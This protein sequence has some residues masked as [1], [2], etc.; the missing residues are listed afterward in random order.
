MTR[1]E[2]IEKLKTLPCYDEGGC[3]SCED[4]DFQKAIDMAA[5]S[6]KIVET[7]SVMVEM[8]KQHG[9]RQTRTISMEALADVMKG[10]VRK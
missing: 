3:D 8:H 2:A 5:D 10:C 4:C 9:N 6:L 7:L 1:E